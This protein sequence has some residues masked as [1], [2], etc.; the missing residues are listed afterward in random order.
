MTSLFSY[1]PKFHPAFIFSFFSLQDFLLSS[2]FLLLQ[3]I[4]ASRFHR[5]SLLP[6]SSSASFSRP[7]CFSILLLPQSI[8]SPLKPRA[9]LSAVEPSPRASLSVRNLTGRRRVTNPEQ[10]QQIVPRG[11]PRWALKKPFR[12]KKATDSC[13]T[14]GSQRRA[15]SLQRN[16]TCPEAKTYV[17]LLSDK[18]GS[19][20]RGVPLENAL[21]CI[22]REKNTADVWKITCDVWCKQTDIIATTGGA[23]LL[24]PFR[25]LPQVFCHLSHTAGKNNKNDTLVLKISSSHPRPVSSLTFHKYAHVFQSGGP[26]DQAVAGLLPVF[27]RTCGT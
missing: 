10:M 25:R 4:S 24:G 12:K 20:P 8:S 19:R 2:T 17:N 14:S 7:L 26:S 23:C 21:I 5:P 9:L 16:T 27:F 3:H 18:R 13:K 1:Q 15:N 22:L 11:E 6:F